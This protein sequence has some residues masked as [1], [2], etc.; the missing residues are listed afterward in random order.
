M[1]DLIHEHLKTVAPTWAVQF[2]NTHLCCSEST[3]EH[4]LAELQRKVLAIAKRTN[5][6]EDGSEGKQEQNNNRSR[7]GMKTNTFTSEELVRIRKAM[8][9]DE[10]I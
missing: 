5:E 9:N 10:D 1:R 4:Q 7:L 3:T 6:I 8:A 2:Q